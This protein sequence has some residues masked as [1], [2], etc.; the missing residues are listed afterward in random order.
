MCSKKNAFP[1]PPEMLP[2]GSS[3]QSI[4]LR[5]K[6]LK[7]FREDVFTAALE[8]SV[9]GPQLRNFSSNEN[10]RMREKAFF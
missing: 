3:W 1:F 6:G 7:N 10:D 2:R 8:I 4:P 5:G 9:S